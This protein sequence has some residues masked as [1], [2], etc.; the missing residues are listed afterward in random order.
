MC[1]FQADLNYLFFHLFSFISKKYEGPYLGGTVSPRPLS[2]S[3]LSLGVGLSAGC[4]P[5]RRTA[6]ASARPAPRPAPRPSSPPRP[7]FRSSVSL[8]SAPAPPSP[9][10]LPFWRFSGGVSPRPGLPPPSGDTWPLALAPSSRAGRVVSAAGRWGLR[11][12]PHRSL[13]S[14]V[15][16]ARVLIP[17]VRQ[18]AAATGPGRDNVLLTCPSRT[19]GWGR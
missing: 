7:G 8:N 13:F 1:C 5:L 14:L 2:T 19:V 6:Y 18:P 17:L 4:G 9:L 12:A 16:L 10:S 3:W 15:F 11:L